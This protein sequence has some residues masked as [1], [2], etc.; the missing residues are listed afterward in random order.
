MPPSPSERIQPPPPQARSAIRF[1]PSSA[2]VLDNPK[3][4]ENLR[5]FSEA[6][7]HVTIVDPLPNILPLTS[8]SSMLSCLKPSGF[9][10]PP[11]S[12]SNDTPTYL[13]RAPLETTLPVSRNLQAP[14]KP[15]KYAPLCFNLALFCFLF[16]FFRTIPFVS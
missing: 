13:I 6:H 1:K 9:S 5:Q 3:W 8:R 2:Q 12:P 4:I 16:L 14:S 15:L 10:L 7:P 11:A